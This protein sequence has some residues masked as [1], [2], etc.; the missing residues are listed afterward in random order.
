[1]NPGPGMSIDF[2]HYYSATNNYPMW[3]E[4]ATLTG[5]WNGLS[6]W[7]AG[8]GQDAHSAAYQDP[9]L[10]SANSYRPLAGSPLIDSGV[11][12]VNVPFDFAGVA[13]PQG[14]AFDKGA[15]EVLSVSAPVPSLLSAVSGSGQSTATSTS[16]AAPLVARVT[17]N[18]GAAVPGVVVTF[19]AP[20]TG[21]GATFSGSSSRSVMTDANGLAAS[22]TVTANAT[23]GSYAVT[24]SAGTLTPVF[25]PL[26][27]TSAAPQLLPTTIAIN[28]GTV[29]GKAKSFT[30]S[31]TVKSNGNSVLTGEVQFFVNGVVAGGVLVKNGRVQWSM[32]ILPNTPSGTQ[33]AIYARFLANTIYA[34]SQSETVF[35]QVK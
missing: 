5:Y 8:T 17:D 12:L 18:L 28:G 21:A 9:Q 30:F 35:V 26:Q 7:Q 29:S 11:T 10:D 16:F 25:F 4:S 15:F 3:W 23:A 2:N 14:R 6:A 34:A 32:P 20:A 13:R 33:F 31:G 22:S 1:V 24:A 19:S 27:N